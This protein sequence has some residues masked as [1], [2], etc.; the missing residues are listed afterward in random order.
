MELNW[1]HLRKSFENEKHSVTLKYKKQDLFMDLL[2]DVIIRKPLF[3]L[4][5][6]R[7]IV[8]KG[9]I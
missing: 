7:L 4:F 3:T 6:L 2:Y 5:K 9:V 8:I 1:K